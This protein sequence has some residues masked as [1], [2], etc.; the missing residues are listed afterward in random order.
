M[1]NTLAASDYGLLDQNT[2][3]PRPSYWATLLWHKLMG[4]TVLDPQ[5]SAAP[6][7]YVYAQCG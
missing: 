2:F 1:H 5:I 4:M 7:T 6:N 3:E